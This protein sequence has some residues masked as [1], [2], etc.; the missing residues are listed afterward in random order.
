MNDITN[1]INID[2]LHDLQ[3]KMP[4]TPSFRN[5][6]RYDDICNQNLSSEK[7]LTSNMGSYYFIK[8]Q[9]LIIATDLF[10]LNLYKRD[11]PKYPTNLHR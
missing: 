3:T 11:F 1:L 4:N 6:I 9:S 7:K 5:L 8:K 10:V 2:D